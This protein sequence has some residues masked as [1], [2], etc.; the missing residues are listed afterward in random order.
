MSWFKLKFCRFGVGRDEGP[1]PS[2]RMGWIRLFWWPRD[3]LD[4]ISALEH[5]LRTARQ[6][7]QCAR[8]ELEDNQK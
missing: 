7:N 5:S 1:P 3:C 4:L 2:I 6:A 8:R